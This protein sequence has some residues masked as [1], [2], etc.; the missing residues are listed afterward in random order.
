[1]WGKVRS[2]DWG[3]HSWALTLGISSMGYLTSRDPVFLAF[4]CVS[5]PFVVLGLFDLCYDRLKR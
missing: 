3:S 2:F 1:M 4:V 5:L